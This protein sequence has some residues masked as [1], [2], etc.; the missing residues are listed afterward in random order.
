MLSYAEYLARE[1]ASEVKHEYL[2][3]DVWA[4]AGGTPRHARLCA[5]MSRTVGARLAG[6]PCVPYSSDLRVRVEA[7]DRSTYPDLTI[8]CGADQ[9]AKDDPDAITN[10]TVLIEVLSETTERSDRGEKFA[11]YQH[12]PSLQ[13][14]V[15]VS[16]D[17]PRIEVFRRHEKTWVLSIFEAGE[18]VR[19]ESLGIEFEVDAVYSDPRE[20]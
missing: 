1:A 7:T 4:M 17:S 12:L 5:A 14:Y 20:R 2:R 9:F 11:H 10:P 18:V 3:G 15:L 6:K 16:Q 13:E 8:V 19:L